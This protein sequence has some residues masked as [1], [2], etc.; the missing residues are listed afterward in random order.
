M[1]DQTKNEAQKFNGTF[2]ADCLLFVQDGLYVQSR[3]KRKTQTMRKVSAWISVP[4]VAGAFGALLWL[5]RRRPLRRSVEAKLTRDARNLAVAG[6]AAVALQLAERPVTRR[7]TALVKRRKFGLLQQLPLPR[8]LEIALAVVL[9]DYTLYVWHVLT[10]RVPWLWRFHLV[11]HADLDLDASTALRFHF[12]ELICS[13]A[14]RAAQVLIIGVSPQAL[15]AW[16]GL[17]FVSILFHHSNVRLPI[18]AERRLNLFI[19]TPRMHGIHHSLVREERDANWSSGLTVWDRLHGTLKL[20]VP[21][22]EITIGVPDYREAKKLRLIEI[23]KLPFGAVESSAWLLPDEAR[24]PIR[25]PRPA[26]VDHLLA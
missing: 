2:C 7:L 21:Q 14:W 8:P 19:V 13:V 3:D 20:N 1:R 17:L 6:V 23:L 24:P 15:A 25:A 11:H 26:S 4:L 9:L 16:Q 5:E 10:H 22:D 18:E 12:G